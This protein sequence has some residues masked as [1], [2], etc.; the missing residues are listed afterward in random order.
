MGLGP[1]SVHITNYYHK[2]SG[3]ISTVYNRLLKEAARRG[4]EVRLIVPGEEDREEVIGETAKIYFVKA[5]RSPVF[6]KR[7]RLILPWQYLGADSRMRHIL[8]TEKPDII[9]IAD[10]Y[11]ISFLAGF[12]KRG[13]YKALER[14]MLV[15]L[16]CERMDD[17]LRA[18]LS[19][20]GPLRSLAS[21]F[22]KNYVAPMFDYHFANS[23]Y[24]AGELVDAVDA[25]S[26]KKANFAWRFFRAR[27]EDFEKRVFTANCG[28][29]TEMFRADRKSPE[30]RKKI[31]HRIRV[32]ED[33][34][35][36]LY[37]G[38]ISPEKNIGLLEGVARSLAGLSGNHKGRFRMVI[39]GDGPRADWLISRLNEI[40]P[41]AFRFLGHIKDK[42]YLA[43]LYA[44][45][46]V[47]LHPNPRE[48]FGIGPLEAMASGTPVVA[49][50][51]GGVLT[52]ANESNSWLARPEPESF[53]AAVNE[54][55]Y[56][57]IARTAKVKEALAT[58]ERFKWSN[59]FDRLFSLY[60]EL[61]AEFTERHH[62]SEVTDRVSAFPEPLDIGIGPAEP[63]ATAGQNPA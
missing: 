60:D 27:P 50:D 51:S 56:N 19:A 42:E 6:D 37:A 62:T 34:V 31:C 1:K 9:E 16:S 29:D 30:N 15:H 46:D 32:P 47:F 22:M 53:S 10:K 48:P 18:F 43:D 63:S 5:M 4:R 61:Y 54:I 20:A 8:E 2:S 44:N 23:D 33:D 35:L 21:A 24:T 13:N 41:D 38:R 17:N 49:P 52:Y 7:Y 45:S 11:T 57:D 26:A 3:G 59:S 55:L 14:P 36:L 39:A 25:Q 58:A 12:I 28:V 40:S